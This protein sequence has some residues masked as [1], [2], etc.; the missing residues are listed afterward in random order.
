[1]FTRFFA[2]VFG[3][4]SNP[5]LEMTDKNIVYSTASILDRYYDQLG[6]QYLLLKTVNPEANHDLGLVKNLD[7]KANMKLAAFTSLLIQSK[8]QEVESLSISDIKDYCIQDLNLNKDQITEAE[9]VL[10]KAIGHENEC[11]TLFDFVMFYI[12][13]LKLEC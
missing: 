2:V 10:R 13:L 7:A 9:Y 5:S 12:R 4:C 11:T 6:K 1:V 3:F 8:N